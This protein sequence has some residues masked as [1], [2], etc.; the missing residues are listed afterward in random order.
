MADIAGIG[1][2]AA[3]TP[4]RLVSLARRKAHPDHGGT[5]ETW[6]RFTDAYQQ[7]VRSIREQV[8]R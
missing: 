3:G 4:E 2:D 5:S 8:S 7:Q 1:L 6:A